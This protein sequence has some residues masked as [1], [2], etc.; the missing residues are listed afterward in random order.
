MKLP[1]FFRKKPKELYTVAFY[2]VE[3]LFDTTED[4]DI[5]DRDFIPTSDRKWNDKRYEKKLNKIAH[6]ISSIG[7]TENK[8]LPVMV[9]LAEVENEGVIKDLLAT[10]TLKDKGYAYIHYNSPDERG[11][12]T[13][14]IY[15]TN[16]IQVT[17]SQTHELYLETT[18]G[19]RDFTRDILEV[20]CNFLGEQFTILVNHWPS[21]RDGASSTVYKR[22]EAA[23][24]NIAI[25]NGIKSKNP[26]N[27]ILVMGDFNDDPQ[28]ESVQK[29]SSSGLF[30]PME[31]LLTNARGTTKHKGRWNLFDQILMSYD[32][33]QYRKGKLKFKSA[34]IYDPDFLKQIRGRYKGS[35][36]RTFGGRKYTGGYSD[37]FPV[38]ILL[39]R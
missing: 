23:N 9:G 32:L 11:I 37:H 26:K 31:T 25:I 5:L 8:Y 39:E 18:E 34:A 22:I 24:R 33:L 21:R 1:K 15:R 19:I 13:A 6:A 27:H 3:N 35:P 38:Y 4:K 36:Y 30:N 12:D 20:N 7:N 14:F 16:Y 10:E 2:N 29:L 17:S 28:D